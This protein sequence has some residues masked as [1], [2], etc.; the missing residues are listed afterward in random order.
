MTAAPLRAQLAL[1][2]LT[3]PTGQSESTWLEQ[4]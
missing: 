1:Y 3:D 4:V 2:W